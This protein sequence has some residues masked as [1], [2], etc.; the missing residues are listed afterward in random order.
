MPSRIDQNMNRESVLRLKLLFHLSTA[1]KIIHKNEWC[2]T[3]LVLLISTFTS[4]WNLF[5]CL[6]SFFFWEKHTKKKINISCT[7]LSFLH[8]IYNRAFRISKSFKWKIL[9]WE[10]ELI[11]WEKRNRYKSEDE[12][13]AH[14]RW[15]DGL[16]LLD[17]LSCSK[18]LKIETYL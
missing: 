7:H 13:G 5:A 8:T 2:S 14:T 6:I 10:W 17:S 3:E 16:C 18:T 15:I 4:L 9:R 11:Y 12:I 1:T